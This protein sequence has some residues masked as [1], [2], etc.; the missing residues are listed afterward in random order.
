MCGAIFV[1]GEILSSPIVLATESLSLPLILGGLFWELL[2]RSTSLPY[3]S[4][5]KYHYQRSFE[6][7]FCGLSA[8]FL[9]W[10]CWLKKI[11]IL[12]CLLNLT[13]KF[14]TRNLTLLIFKRK[15]YPCND[16]D[17]SRVPFVSEC[18]QQF[19]SLSLDLSAWWPHTTLQILRKRILTSE[20]SRNNGKKLFRWV[21]S[22]IYQIK[23]DVKFRRASTFMNGVNL[24][25]IGAKS[26][27]RRIVWL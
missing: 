25:I 1:K 17:L 21:I 27:C 7:I 4:F 12:L 13:S 10:R 9:L 2:K 3:L 20:I 18:S 8:P 23:N 11:A 24:M 5:T 19:G 15:K 22:Q 26:C 14:H 6:T 16:Y